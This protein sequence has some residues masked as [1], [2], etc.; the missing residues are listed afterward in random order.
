MGNTFQKQ[1]RTNSVQKDTQPDSQKVARLREPQNTTSQA[2]Y[3]V[4]MLDDPDIRVRGEA[5]CS[6]ML[7]SSDIQQ[8]LELALSDSSPNLRAF[9][10]L[11]LANRGDAGAAP[12]IMPLAR[13]PDPM[14]RS[15]ALG[16]LGHLKYARAAPYIRECMDDDYPEVRRS[17]AH[18]MSIITPAR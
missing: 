1:S 5:F 8:V 2:E 10:S 13:D 4:R 16:A 7:N 9:C 14:V 18:A 6:L 15:C 17:A 3:A 12:D 11:V